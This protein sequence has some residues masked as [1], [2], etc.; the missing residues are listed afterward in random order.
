L[1]RV[2][3]FYGEQ[4]GCSRQAI[5]FPAPS[6]TVAGL[7]LIRTVMSERREDS[8]SLIQLPILDSK[9]NYLDGFWEWVRRLQQDDYQGA[10]DGL[11]WPQ[12]SSWTADALRKRVT[13]FFGGRDPW[14]VVIPNDR[15]VKVIN[16]AAEFEGRNAEGQGW[17]LAQIPLTTDAERPKRDDIPLM[18]LAVSFFLRE[19]Q[20]RYVMEFEIFHL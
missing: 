6:G 8:Q 16:D 13:T 7:R 12:G 17:L 2:V 11:Y 18:G 20:S 4:G 1:P 10:L 5:P 9:E 3:S 15:L 19:Y 14:A